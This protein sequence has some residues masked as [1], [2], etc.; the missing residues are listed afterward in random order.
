MTISTDTRTRV[1]VL[2]TSIGLALVLL[3]AGAV[4]AL[5][6]DAPLP[7]VEPAQVEHI[8][9]S[10]DTLWGIASVHVTAGDDVRV[11][12]E[13]IKHHNDLA[14]SIIVP[15]QVLRIPVGD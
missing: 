5:A 3:L 12:I 4:V 2:L 10:G 8:V 13:D 15:G 1:A 14:S 7:A 11:L 6:D 9:R